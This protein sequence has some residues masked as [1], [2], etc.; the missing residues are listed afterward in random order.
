MQV[1]VCVYN[2]GV[3]STLQSMYSAALMLEAWATIAKPNP[4]EFDERNLESKIRR[5][6]RS[7]GFRTL[8]VRGNRARVAGLPCGLWIGYLFM[9]VSRMKMS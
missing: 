5:G 7:C 3:Q 9:F 1:T 8:Y 6:S 4:T 2:Y